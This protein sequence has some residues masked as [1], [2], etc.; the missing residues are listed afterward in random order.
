MS[1]LEVWMRSLGLH[2]V[3]QASA[4]ASTALT[5][6]WQPSLL[7][8]AVSRHLTACS[9]QQLQTLSLAPLSCCSCS[10][11]WLCHNAHVALAAQQ[12]SSLHTGGA[13]HAALL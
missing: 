8:G 3:R 13:H 11:I 5:L 4:K 9:P 1:V 10:S 6:C 2:P 7:A 12:S